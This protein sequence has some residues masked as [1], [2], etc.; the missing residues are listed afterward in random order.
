MLQGVRSVDAV[1]ILL[2]SI[3]PRQN[4]LLKIITPFR[5][6][7]WE[8]ELRNAGIL[9]RF[10]DIVHNMKTGFPSGVPSILCETYTLRNHMSSLLAPDQIQE[11]IKKELAAGC[12]SGPFSKSELERLIGYFCTSPLGA[13]PKPNSDKIQLVQ[14]LSYPRS[15]AY[16]TSVNSEINSDDF[17][18]KWGSFSEAYLFIA[19]APLGTQA[20]VFDVEAT[21]RRI[22]MWPE[23]QVHGIVMWLE[24]FYIDHC[25][26]FGGSSMPGIFGRIADTIVHIFLHYGVEGIL[27]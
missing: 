10:S 14:D 15:N 26:C 12:Y 2:R 21:F 27:K 7:A 18:C 16:H 11:N 19:Q 8:E 1:D 22:L 24:D 6:Q 20:A 4:E 25:F 23:D 17:P 5:W 3:L 9:D 13:V